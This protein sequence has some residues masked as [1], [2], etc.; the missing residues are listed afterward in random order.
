MCEQSKNAAAAP[1][2]NASSGRM[3]SSAIHMFQIFSPNN[4][5]TQN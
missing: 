1:D 3:R 4:I 2:S 5:A